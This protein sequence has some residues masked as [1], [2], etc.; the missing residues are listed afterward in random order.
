MAWWW[1][2]RKMEGARYQIQPSWH[3]TGSNLFPAGASHPD[4][5]QVCKHVSPLETLH[6]QILVSHGEDDFHTFLGGRELP[7]FM[8]PL[9]K[10]SAGVMGGQ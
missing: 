2:V 8:W 9:W 3:T 1:E 10:D 4:K 5:E 7:T 6:M